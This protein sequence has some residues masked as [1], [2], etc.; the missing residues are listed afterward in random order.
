MQC[1]VQG[2]LL[3]LAARY[4]PPRQL[5]HVIPLLLAC[6]HIEHAVGSTHRPLRKRCRFHSDVG[7]A[8][9]PFATGRVVPGGVSCWTDCVAAGVAAGEYSRL[10]ARSI[11]PKLLGRR[12]SGRGMRRGGD[13]WR[14]CCSC[15]CCCCCCAPGRAGDCGLFGSTAPLMFATMK[16]KKEG[17]AGEDLQPGKNAHLE[18]CEKGV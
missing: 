16:E 11:G 5:R 2:V 3:L 6:A 14:A 18:C 13:R 15:C 7:D 10:T 17:N 9:Q 12:A 4:L 8:F 1:A